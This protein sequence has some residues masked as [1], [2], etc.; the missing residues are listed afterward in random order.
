MTQA[1]TII[2]P[3]GTLQIRYPAYRHE[4]KAKSRTC[5][6]VYHSFGPRLSAEE[7]FDTAMCP[8]VPDPA[9]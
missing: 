1:V 8:T 9:S 5:Y 6:H 7:G 3:I 2:T 4:F